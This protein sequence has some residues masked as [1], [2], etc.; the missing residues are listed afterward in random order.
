ML[1]PA[2]RVVHGVRQRTLDAQQALELKA[3]L[4]GYAAQRPEVAGLLP[5]LVSEIDRETTQSDR[6]E[7]WMANFPQLAD[8]TDRMTVDAKRLRVSLK[9]WGVVIRNLDRT[10]G[11][12]LLSREDIAKQAGVPV[13]HA[14][15][16]LAE[17]VAWNVLRRFQNGRAAMWALNPNIA[18]RLPGAAGEAA[19]KNAG[20]VLS[21]HPG[22]KDSDKGTVR[23]PRQV[24][25]FPDL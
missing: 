8:V 23:D 14:S 24:E 13:N 5:V 4:T 20:V 19:R 22:G 7:F 1:K 2:L 12:V 15:A 10:N 9:V 3:V 6:W 18:T 11:A 17:L 16:A 25:A 21:V